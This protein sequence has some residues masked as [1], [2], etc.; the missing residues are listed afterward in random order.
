MGWSKTPYSKY[1]AKKVVVDGVKF[2]SKLEMFCYNV[3]TKTGI[4]FDFQVKVD[5]V[6]KFR[7]PDGVAVRACTMM[8][9][10]VLTI[11]GLKL[12]VDTKGYP[13]PVSK[14]KY[15]LLKYKIYLE[16]ENGKVVFL[17]N[18]K[19]VRD[20]AYKVIGNGYT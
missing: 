6:P 9:D 13:T 12:Y 14:L 8:V 5:L 17:K 18:Q 3:F 4:P 15:K 19:Q 20:F 1:K 7:E 10:F 11:N 16:K 2:D